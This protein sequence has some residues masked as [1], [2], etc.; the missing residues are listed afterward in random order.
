MLLRA[1]D[2]SIYR[3]NLILLSVR[4]LAYKVADRI[5]VL[6]RMIDRGGKPGGRPCDGD[7]ALV[8]ILFTAIPLQRIYKCEECGRYHWA[9]EE[10]A[11]SFGG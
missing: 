7:T 3:P 2:Y 8:I 6:R 1:D 10:R 9:D 5:A 11:A 4:H